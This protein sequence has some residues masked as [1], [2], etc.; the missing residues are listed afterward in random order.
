MHHAT[1][2]VVPLSPSSHTHDRRKLRTHTSRRNPSRLGGLHGVDD[3]LSKRAKKDGRNGNGTPA[4]YDSEQTPSGRIR[5]EDSREKVLHPFKVS[6]EKSMMDLLEIRKAV[7]I[8][9]A[10]KL[11]KRK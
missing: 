7:G 11:G 9:R 1:S 8:T 5:K 2:L 10:S 3:V 6:E 4:G